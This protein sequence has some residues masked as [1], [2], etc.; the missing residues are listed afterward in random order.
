MRIL[1]INTTDTGGGAAI[2][3][4]R[5]HDGLLKHGIDSS[6]LVQEKR[7]FS[8]SVYVHPQNFLRRFAKYRSMID[9]LPVKL[10]DPLKTRRFSVNW[11]PSGIPEKIKNLNPDIVHLHY[12]N[13]GFVRLEELKRLNVPIVWTLHDQWP[14]TGGC[15]LICNCR[16]FTYQCGYCPELN[17]KHYKDLSYKNHLRKQSIYERLPLT[18]VAPSQ[19]IGSLAKNSSLLSKETL[20]VIS[21]GIDTN[22]FT[23]TNKKYARKQLHL[24]PHKKYL[25]F[26]AIHATNN[27]NKG[28]DLLQQA[29][30]QLSDRDIEILI[31]GITSFKKPPGLKYPVHAMGFIKDEV[32]MAQ[33]Y[34][35][36]DCFVL[37]SRQENLPNTAIESL[38]CGTPVVAFDIGGFPDIIDHKHNGYLAEPFNTDDLAYG[39]QWCIS[40]SNNL[41]LESRK[42]ALATFSTEKVAQGYIAL[43]QSLQR[44][45]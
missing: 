8:S 45:S 4:Y 3:A 20:Y 37:P 33:L 36:A 28:W 43:Y 24:S 29:I 11:L 23:P 26:G 5:I 18:I 30:N 12:I 44:E 39:I 42:K 32:Q 22:T 31:F 17:S 19:W 9:K 14:F 2:A 13:N 27:R 1:H 41:S 21:N 35:T 15:H 7:S 16:R 34:N 25:L 40:Q 6:F 38:A 10:R